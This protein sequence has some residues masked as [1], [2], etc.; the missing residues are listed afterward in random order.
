M[1]QNAEKI[2]KENDYSFVAVNCGKIYT[3]KKRGVSPILDKIDE[4][5]EFFIGS[6]VADK[7][8]GKAS[9]MLL[10]KYGV[11]EIFAKLTSEKAI[12]FLKNKN[13]KFSYDSKTEYIINRDKTDM[14]PMEKA[15]LNIDDV[16]IGEK[17]IRDKIKQLMKG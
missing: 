3:S 7:V 15:V 1:T 14:C 10:V 4:N 6:S 2:L 5:P 9:A 17:A 16:N 12:E 13:V 11:S 8:I